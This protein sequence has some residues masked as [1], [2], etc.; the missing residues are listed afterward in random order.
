MEAIPH[1]DLVEQLLEPEAQLSELVGLLSEHLLHQ[2]LL[3]KMT[4]MRISL[5][6]LKKS[7]SHR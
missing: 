6:I 2:E 5:L 1:S 3:Q 4:L 7:K